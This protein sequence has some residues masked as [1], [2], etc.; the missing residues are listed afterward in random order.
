MKQ[1]LIS[2]GSY[3]VRGNIAERIEHYI[4]LSYIRRFSII[5]VGRFIT[6]SINS[7]ICISLCDV[8]PIDHKKKKLIGLPVEMHPYIAKCHICKNFKLGK[9]KF[10]ET[11]CC[12]QPVCRVCIRLSENVHV[13]SVC[14][15]IK[16]H[17]CPFLGFI[18]CG[19]CNDT[20][21]RKKEFCIDCWM[22]IC[23]NK[24]FRCVGCDEYPGLAPHTVIID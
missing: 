23:V 2:D 10:K 3:Y 16:C 12:E 18:R 7:K 8:T 19:K 9:N 1:V 14:D 17:T 13:C 5:S 4:T 22:R 24:G 15:I 11:G 6:R 20:R 21:R